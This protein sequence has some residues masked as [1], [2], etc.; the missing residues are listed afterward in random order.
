MKDEKTQTHF[1][2]LSIFLIILFLG[3]FPNF[4]GV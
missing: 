1:K 2:I 4:M 3:I